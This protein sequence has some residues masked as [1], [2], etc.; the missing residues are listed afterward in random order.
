MYYFNDMKFSYFLLFL[1]LYLNYK[2]GKRK[3]AILS[4]SEIIII[5]PNTFYISPHSKQDI[6]I[7]NKK[8]LLNLFSSICVS[9]IEKGENYNDILRKIVLDLLI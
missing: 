3:N 6:A 7:A 8:E 1:S 4:H 9:C 2:I 5:N